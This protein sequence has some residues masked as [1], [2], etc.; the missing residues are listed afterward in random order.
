MLQVAK[1]AIMSLYQILDC[2]DIFLD[3][4]PH[5]RLLYD[6]LD[7]IQAKNNKF[8]FHSELQTYNR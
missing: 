3:H 2:D 6:K 8:V 5:M 1:H 4:I 7:K